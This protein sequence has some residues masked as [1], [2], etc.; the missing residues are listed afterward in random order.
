MK[1]DEWNIHP[2]VIKRRE[3]RIGGFGSTGK[4]WF[5]SINFFLNNRKYIIKIN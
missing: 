3:I 5:K 4:Y 2:E 1:M